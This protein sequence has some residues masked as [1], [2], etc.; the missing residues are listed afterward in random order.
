MNRPAFS[1]ADVIRAHAAEYAALPGARVTSSERRVLNDLGSCRTS[2]LGGHVDRCGACERESISYNS[3]RNRHCPT[4]LAHRSA[5]WLQER[6]SELLPVEYFHVVFTIPQEVAALALGNKKVVFDVLF[7]SVVRTLRKIA[8]DRRRLGAKIGGLAILHTWSQQLDFHPHIHCVIPGGGLSN[9]GSKWISCRRKFFLPV[10][11]LSRYFRGN[12][13]ARLARAR[14]AGRL[15]F[16][17]ST[18]SL[19]DDR[20][21]G[22]WVAALMKKEWVVYAKPP[23]GSPEHVLKYLAR[24][25]HRVAISNS[26]IVD[27]AEGRVSFRF[28]DAKRGNTTHV[29]SMAATEFLRRFLL[30]TLP[31]GFVRIRHFGIFGNRCRKANLARCRELLGVPL[32][33][34]GEDVTPELQNSDEPKDARKCKYCGSTHLVPV[35]V[36]PHGTPLGATVILRWDTS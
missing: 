33:A 2:L 1:V 14:A 15:H 3:C 4:C 5:D 24:Y 28:R 30:H 29:T 32:V 18:E 10:R 35:G 8:V 12:F 21:F 27:V 16:G 11:V 23:F 20:N 6:R 17:G 25:T 36:V 19:A 7:E 13:L 31:S 9:D 22:A 26:R 34:T